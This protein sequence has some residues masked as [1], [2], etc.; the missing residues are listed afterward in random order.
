MA[1]AGRAEDDAA[2]EFGRWLFAQ[3]CTF[4]AGAASPDALPAAD[5]PEAA[6]AGRSNVGKSSLLN[7]LTGRK[8]LARTS[9]TPGRTRQLNFFD[10]GGRLALVD[11][12]GFGYARAAKAEI[13]GWTRLTRDYL[14]GRP[15]LRRLCLLVDARHGLKDSDREIAKLLDETAVPYQVVLTK[16]DKTKPGA[17]ESLCASVAEEMARHPACHPDVIAT[18]S[19]TGAGIAELRASLAALAERGREDRPVS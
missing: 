3:T 19:V 12:P 2:L 14:R 11:L 6:F 13:K 5:L 16:A 1:E 8:T 15:T 7:A 9:H 18:S 17:L 10:L 4:T